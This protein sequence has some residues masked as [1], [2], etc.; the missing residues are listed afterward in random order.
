MSAP[1]LASVEELRA[2][3]LA[4]RSAVIGASAG[5]PSQGSLPLYRE[6]ARIAFETAAA[7]TEQ[8]EDRP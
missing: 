4:A 3:G 1:M 7:N 5:H 8:P 6:S 2:E